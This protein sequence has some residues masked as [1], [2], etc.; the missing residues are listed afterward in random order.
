MRIWGGIIEYRK[1]YENMGRDNG[2][3]VGI[4]EYR[5]R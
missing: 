2:M 3:H 5:G 1:E 4:M